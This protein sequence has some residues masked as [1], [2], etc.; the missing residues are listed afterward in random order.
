MKSS[1]NFFEIKY[2]ANSLCTRTNL[3]RLFFIKITTVDRGEPQFQNT[4]LFNKITSP[5]QNQTKLLSV[6]IA[7][8]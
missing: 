4:V 6:I 8:K 5:N 7:S 2:E 3:Y 1:Q